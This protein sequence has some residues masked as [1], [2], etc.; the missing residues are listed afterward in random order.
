MKNCP[1]WL[2]MKLLFKPTDPRYSVFRKVLNAKDMPRL[3]MGSRK[4]ESPFRNSLLLEVIR[5]GRLVFFY[6]R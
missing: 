2:P 1:F 3:F 4:E 5:K 6:G